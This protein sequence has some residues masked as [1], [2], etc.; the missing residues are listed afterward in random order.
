MIFLLDVLLKFV[1]WFILISAVVLIFSGSAGFKRRINHIFVGSFIVALMIATSGLLRTVD[2]DEEAAMREIV[3]TAMRSHLTE[4]MHSELWAY[5]D[6]QPEKFARQLEESS[7]LLPEYNRQ[8]WI[9]ASLSAEAQSPVYTEEYRQL[10]NQ[11]LDAGLGVDDILQQELINA[12]ATGGFIRDGET[13]IAITQELITQTI[14]QMDYANLRIRRLF[15]RDWSNEPFKLSYPLLGID[16][17]SATGFERWTVETETSN[18]ELAVVRGLAHE[19]ANSKIEVW[20]GPNHPDYR[21][22]SAVEITSSVCDRHWEW[23]RRDFSNQIT[24]SFTDPWRG[25]PSVVEVA[26][27]SDDQSSGQERIRCVYLHDSDQIMSMIT[28]VVGIS[29]PVDAIG[30][31]FEKSI[32]LI[33]T[34]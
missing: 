11:I 26:N 33:N 22:L 5:V 6:K 10:F 23:T 28:T 13:D 30:D 18:G 8:T 14:S 32:T 31:A 7:S 20:V 24:S 15:D 29:Q 25:H 1:L 17:V 21:G 34:E 4:E 27:V 19:G 16:V 3:R 9:S 12:A 2:T